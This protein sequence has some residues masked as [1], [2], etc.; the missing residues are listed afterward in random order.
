M[1]TAFLTLFFEKFFNVDNDAG[2]IE[3][4]IGCGVTASL[5]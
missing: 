3:S 1:R 2:E 4:H 5:L